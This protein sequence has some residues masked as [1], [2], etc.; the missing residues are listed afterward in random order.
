[1]FFIVT[2]CWEALIGCGQV[3]KNY[4][5]MDIWMPQHLDLNLWVPKLLKVNEKPKG[6]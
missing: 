4:F 3:I 2:G 6:H 1:M 5:V